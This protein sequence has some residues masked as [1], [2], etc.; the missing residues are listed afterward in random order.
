[1]NYLMF[2][3]EIARYHPMSPEVQFLVSGS[4]PVV[5]NTVLNDVV[6]KCHEH[7]RTLVIVDDTGMSG[8]VDYS[9]M[10]SWGYHVKNGMSGEYCL[11]NP[12]QMTGVKEISKMRQLLETLGYDEKQKAK[13]MAYFHFIR[14]IESLERGSLDV[15]LTLETFRAYCTAMAV[16]ERLQYL[17]DTGVIDDRQQMYLLT[18]YS[19]CCAAAA[20]FEDTFF[21]LMPFIRGKC[22]NP[23]EEPDQAFVFPVGEL[24]EDET[25]RNLV[26]QLFLFGLEVH[27]AAHM[28][29]LIFDRGYGSR[30]SIFNFLKSMPAWVSTHVF[31]EDIFTLCDAPTLA[32]VL[33]RFTARVYSRH[34][35]M[36]SCQAIEK[37]CGEIDV[38]KNSYNVTYDRHWR[39][40]RPWDVLMGKNKTEAYTQMAP[41]REPR[42]RK[43]MIMSLPPGNGIVEFM[44]N[45]SLLGI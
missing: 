41:V 1:M 2:I 23:G 34:L 24:G 31:S 9:M 6:R 35:A 15:Q 4:D 22:I 17:V 45:I 18:K 32:M 42:Y 16:E 13:L 39:S 40:N 30:K 44:G 11:Y 29:V 14:H 10:T 37:A 27:A 5:R 12:L 38:V 28:T 3:D 43:E 20:D 21:M 36:D 26:M 33:N 19:E 25:I 8:G 7:S